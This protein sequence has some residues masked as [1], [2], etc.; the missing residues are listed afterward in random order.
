MLKSENLDNFKLNNSS[1]QL[2]V[3]ILGMYNPQL[4]FW[5]YILANEYRR[6]Q[7]KKTFYFA[8]SSAL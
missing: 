7:T 3:Y 4:L 8:S 1:D 6:N 5:H 2:I